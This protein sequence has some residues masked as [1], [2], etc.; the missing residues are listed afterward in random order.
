MIS[1]TFISYA[2]AGVTIFFLLTSGTLNTTNANG[3]GA[4][5]G[6]PGETH[7]CSQAGCHG[8]GNGNGT[9]GGLADNAGPGSITISS[10]PAMTNGKYVPGATYSMI[11]T[12]SETGK[13]NFGFDA[14]ILDNSG[15]TNLMV[16]NTAG[17]LIIT[18]PAKTHIVQAFGT[19]RATVTHSL[20]AGQSVNTATFG[21]NWKAPASGT[22]NIYVS[23]TACNNDNLANAQDNVYLNY[24]QITP[25]TGVG[26]EEKEFGNSFNIF[27]N[28]ARDLFVLSGN[29]EED[30][31]VEVK[32]YSQEGKLVKSFTDEGVANAKQK[33][34][35]V[36][37]L[38]SGVYLL[39]VHTKSS[40]VT[41]KLIINQ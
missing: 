12:V 22:V 6:A 30:A 4:S 32:I 34:Y 27:P 10:I 41:K 18:N 7:T 39:D 25:N 35:K 17:T 15:N 33:T 31:P 26:V 24:L 20:N 36:D 3:T 38:S 16:N 14:E 23:G 1:K 2:F 11:V 19:G 5:T 28:P 13:T 21:F 9:S 40:N 29:N 8:A 37:D